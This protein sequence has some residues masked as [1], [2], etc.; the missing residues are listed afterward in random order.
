MCKTHV[1]CG[2][3]L[4]ANHSQLNEEV[5]Q[6]FPSCFRRSARK[7]H[8]QDHLPSPAGFVFSPCICSLNISCTCR[9][10]WSML[11]LLSAS[12]FEENID[13]KS[14]VSILVRSR[15][16]Q[17]RWASVS[18]MKTVSSSL[19]GTVDSTL[20]FVLRS[21]TFSSNFFAAVRNGRE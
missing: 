19:G 12:I 11:S 5:H 13:F 3:S 7:H 4:V 18:G 9:R 14:T 8:G 15:Y 1:Q 6:A 17:N 16:V 2:N 10:P 20:A 21:M